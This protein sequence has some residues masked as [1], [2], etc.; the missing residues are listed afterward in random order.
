MLYR[1]KDSYQRRLALPLAEVRWHPEVP[2]VVSPDL[3]ALPKDFGHLYYV[4]NHS[5]WAREFFFASCIRE[6]QK[7][8]S[9]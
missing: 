4:V 3:L 7:V 8:L 9:G 5:Y 6:R 1:E 2:T